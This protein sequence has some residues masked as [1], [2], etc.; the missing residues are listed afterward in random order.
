MENKYETLRSVKWRT[1]SAKWRT[2]SVNG[3]QEV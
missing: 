2:G 1:G 3:E